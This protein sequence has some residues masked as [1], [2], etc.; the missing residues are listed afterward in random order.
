MNI[1]SYLIIPAFVLSFSSLF[2]TAIAQSMTQSDDPGYSH[3]LPDYRQ[4]LAA[5]PLD[6]TFIKEEKLQDIRVKYYQLS[7]QTWSP[8]HQVSPEKWQHNVIFYI[9]AHPQNQRALVIINNGTNN[10]SSSM[11]A[12]PPTDFTTEMLTRLARET[13][14]IVISVSDIPNQYLTFEND[15]KPRR[16]DDSVARS[17]ALFMQAPPQY[18]TLPL[19]V[20]M[21]GAVSQTLSLAEHELKAWHIKRF[22]LS[23]ISKRGWTSWLTAIADPRVDAIVPFV[24]DLLN[25]REALTHMY[26]SYG[27][28]WPIAFFPYYNEKIDTQITSPQFAQLMQIQDPIAYANSSYKHRLAIPKYIVNASGD[29]FYTPDNS[30][31]YYDKLPGQ[32][33][34]RVVPNSSHYGVK[35]VATE[36]LIPFVKR[37]QQNKALP[38]ISVTQEK[39]TGEETLKIFFSESPVSIKLWS[40]NN[41]LARDFRY[42]CNIRYHASDIPL[43]DNHN[44]TVKLVD[45]TRGWTA[46]FVE[47]TFKDGYVSTTPVVISTDEVYPATPPEKGGPSCQT[48]PGRGL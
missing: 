15:G 40:A 37:I 45:P 13:Q 27:G 47:A 41:P 31:F 25:Q 4:A 43:P 38:A 48:L 22:I 34:L 14:T 7:S 21:S 17:W 2:Q 9:P 1:N 16:E 18:Q 32:K 10:A 30:R 8:Q 33:S 26:K 19:Q 29:D 3:V 36:A 5:T 35:T 23:G 24:I 20:P 12:S 42:A 28:N 39:K 44:L 11:S 6:Y 46:S